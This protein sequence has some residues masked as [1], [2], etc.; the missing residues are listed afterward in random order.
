MLIVYIIPLSECGS[1]AAFCESRVVVKFHA[2]HAAGDS[3]LRV[4][5]GA[6][7]GIISLSS[8]TLVAG[9]SA[10]CWPQGVRQRKCWM[11]YAETNSV[12]VEIEL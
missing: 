10:E 7:G 11:E 3:R 4:G 8:L 1:E 6:F 12:L 2:F 9:R 5:H